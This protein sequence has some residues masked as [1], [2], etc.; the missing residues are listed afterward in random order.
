MLT[1]LKKFFGTKSEKDIKSIQPLVDQALEIYPSLA[2]LSNDELR[3]RVT[4]LK[5]KIQDAIKTEQTE[6]NEIKARIEKDFNMDIDTK[7]ALY[8]EVDEFEKD[9]TKKIEDVLNEILPEAY[10]IL[11]DTSRRFSES[12]E[13]I[14]TANEFDTA[15]SKTHK[16]IEI[17]GSQAAW[18]N[19]WIAAGTEVLW[20]MVHYDVQLIGGTVLHQGKISEMATGEGKTLVSTLPVFLNALSGRGVHVVTVNNYLA[21]RDSEWNAPLFQFHGLSVDCID[22]HDPNTEERRQAYLADITYGTNNEFGF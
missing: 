1:F 12:E 21:K 9:I 14:V 16:N 18:K 22:K 6:I 7:E 19:R 10:A 4:A 2:K 5:Q 13:I 8:K 20:N 17:R 15:L 11:K 3:A